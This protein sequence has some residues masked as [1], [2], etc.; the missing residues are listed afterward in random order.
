MRNQ[1][2][3]FP[4][5]EEQLAV[6]L[7]NSNMRIDR[8]RTSHDRLLAAAKEMVSAVASRDVAS[9]IWTSPRVEALKA[10]IA[11]AKEQAQ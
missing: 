8:L 10:A 9:F 4:T 1:P 3:Q 2:V 6:E 7:D 11:A 5:R